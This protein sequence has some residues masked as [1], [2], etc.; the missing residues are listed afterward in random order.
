[1]PLLLLCV[2]PDRVNFS[3]WV[4][5]LSLWHIAVYCPL[6]HMVWHD[7]GLIKAWHVMDFAGELCG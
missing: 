5:F 7:Q 3:S 1:M 2:L 6:A 4:L